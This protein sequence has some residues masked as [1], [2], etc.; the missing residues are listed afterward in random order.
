MIAG[1]SRLSRT[2]RAERSLLALALAALASVMLLAGGGVSTAS[3]AAPWWH[4]SGEVAPSNLPPQGQ[5]RV[6]VVASNLGDAAVQANGTDP[7]VITDQLPTGLVATGTET[8]IVNGVAVQCTITT[9]ITCKFTGVLNPYERLSIPIE[10]KV[11]E[12][13]GTTASLSQQVTVEGAEVP[14]VTQSVPVTVSAEP[15]SFGAAHYELSAANEDGSPATQA[16]EHPFE[17]TTSLIMNQTAVRQPAALPKD[18]TF[19]LPPGLIGNPNG[20]TQ[21]TIS[22]FMAL[23]EQADL[24]PPSSVIGVA[25]ITANE[26]KVVGIFNKTVPVFNLVPSRGEPARFGFEVIGKVPIVIDTSVR[27]GEDYEVLAHVTDATETAGLLSSEVTLWGVPGDPR[28]NSARGWECVAGGFFAKE[29]GKTC[30]ASGELPLQPFLTMPTSCPTNPA[31]EPL[32]SSLEVDSWANPGSYLSAE[33]AWLSG[34]GQGLNTGDCSVLP[35]NPEIFVSPEQHTAATPTGATVKVKVPQ[36]T[37]LEASGLAEADVRDTTVTLPEGVQLSPSAANDLEACPEESEGGYEGVGFEGFQRFSGQEAQPETQTFTPTFRFSEEEVDGATLAPS[38]PEASKVGNVHIKTPLLSHELEGSVYLASPAPNGEAGKNPF[39]SLVALYMVARDPVSGVLVKLAGRGEVNENTGL[40]STTFANT[41]QVPF[42]ELT[43]ELFSG[44][45]ASLSTPA[46]CGVYSTHAAFTP[47]SGTGTVD[48]SS[49]AE[50]FDISSGVNAEACPGNALP[51]APGFLAQSTNAQAGAFTSFDLE[52]SRPDGDQ[53]LSDVTMHLPQGV[54][55]LLSA[56]E[57]CSE[58]QANNDACPGASE[59]GQATAVAGLGP[60]PYVQSGGKVF[61]TGAYGGA[62]F[63]LEIVTPAVAGPFN[64]GTVTVRS[65]LY[66]NP[67]NASVTIVSDPL[68]T[69]LRGIPL[70]LKRVLVE[71]NRPNFEFNPTDCNPTDVEGTLTGSEGASVNASTPFRVENCA[72]LPFAPTL[73]ASAA[74]HASKADGTTFTV[75]VTSKGLGQANIAKVD[76]Q[77]PEQLPSR[78][79]TIQKACVASVFEGNPAACDEGSLI[80]IATIRTPVLKNPLTGPAYLVSHGN[81]AF[82]DVEFVLQDEG[83]K[84]IL[85]G[86]TDIKHGITYS[87]FESAPD[88]PFTTFETVLPAGPHSALTAN[89]PEHKHF[90]LCGETLQMPTTIVG[91][92]GDVIE[93]DTR[94]AIQGCGAVKAVKARKLTRAQKLALALKACRKRHKQS[95]ATRASCERRARQRYGAKQAARQGSHTS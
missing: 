73:S 3:A 55:A 35:F 1:K 6:I 36:Q 81:A 30:P 92:N 86:K 87:K 74:G 23:V 40:I 33:Y 75:K 2:G 38:C 10:V 14:R 67:E 78:L 5:G 80:G 39:N 43:L 79:P 22:D 49:P 4:L 17:L 53:A 11:E 64:L 32:S 46:R 56:V 91:Q 28:H 21:C 12:P 29:V 13:P 62:P 44:P 19:K 61:I 50:E 25:T 95:R 51:F 94:I 54:A 90:E 45:R 42:E 85:D 77:L 68:P 27:T 24:C 66:I 18:F 34:S 8:V 83:I 31:A 9:L 58:A 93:H 48:V 47:W 52:L 71:V 70:Q 41:P 69:E 59:V 57:L 72:R 26:P 65:K 88:A 20:V 37:T 63:G 60:E 16:G 82:P 15:V 76:L 7:V 84:L 89:V